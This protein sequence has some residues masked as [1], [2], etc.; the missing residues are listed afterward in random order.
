MKVKLLEFKSLG[1]TTAAI[2]SEYLVSVLAQNG[3]KEKLAGFCTYNCYTIFGSLKRKGQNNVF[4]KV[5]ENIKRNL[6]AV[7]CAAHIV[8]NCI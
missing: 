1:G 2:L 8:H 6:T 7:E 5:K 4:F 3:H